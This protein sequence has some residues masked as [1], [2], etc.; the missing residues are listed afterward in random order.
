MKRNGVGL[1]YQTLRA[2][3]ISRIEVRSQITFG[4]VTVAGVLYSFGLS[5]PA[6]A[7]VYPI[8]ALFLAASWTQNDISIKLIGKYIRDNVEEDDPGLQWETWRA[9]YAAN[10]TEISGLRL[11]NL[12]AIGIFTITQAVAL[13]IGFSRYLNFMSLDWIAGILATAFTF[14]TA[15]L[16][17]EYSNRIK[18]LTN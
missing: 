7:F 13:L 8:I 2:E 15:L 9:A 6:V 16:L 1:E 5:N 18:T 4:V 12:S 17:R 3:V 14:L 10:S 11:T